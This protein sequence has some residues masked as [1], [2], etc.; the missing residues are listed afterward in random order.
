MKKILY[1]VLFVI[2]LFWIGI[3]ALKTFVYPIKYIDIIKEEAKNNNIDP[4]LVLAIIKT[5]SSFNAKATSS[6]NA[7]GLM[8]MIESTANEV[9]DR[10]NAYKDIEN[11]DIYEVDIN[12]EL[13]CN[14]FASLIKRYNGNY[15]LAICAYNAGLGNVDKWIDEGIISDNLAD[16]KNTTLPFKETEKYL[17]KV[18]NTYTIYKILYHSS[19]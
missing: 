19:L 3:T 10:I 11:T 9:N 14:Y 12:I 1:L 16:Y 6:K 4:Y 13:G 18:I 7:K 8:Q 17:K 15:Y 2:I 5:E